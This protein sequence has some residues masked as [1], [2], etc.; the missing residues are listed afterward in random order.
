VPSNQHVVHLPKI[1]RLAIAMED[2][3]G[4]PVANAQLLRVKHLGAAVSAG[5]T[6]KTP[7]I[8]PLT[9]GTILANQL[10]LEAT[11]CRILDGSWS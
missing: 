9:N 2:A 11:T 3:G 4:R 6:W 1:T 7:Q 8:R 5:W 10:Q